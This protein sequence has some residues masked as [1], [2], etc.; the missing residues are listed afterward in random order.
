M[1]R[2]GKRFC[3]LIALVFAAGNLSIEAQW[4]TIARAAKNRIQRITEGS[5]DSGF[6][7]ATV[8]LEAAQAR[9]YAKALSM[10][11]ANPEITI[12][13]SDA[14]KGTIQFHKQKQVAAL[15]ITTLSENLTQFVIASSISKE[16]VPS[17][18][19]LVVDAILKVCKEVNVQCTVQP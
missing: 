16:N 6:D 13:G 9:V 14:D 8:M 3:L 2:I 11:K 17:A 7:V 1:F 12:T 4:V 10:L 5:P 18:T 19:P 15:Q